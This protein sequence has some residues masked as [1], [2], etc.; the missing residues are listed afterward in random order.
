MDEVFSCGNEIIKDILL[1]QLH[2]SFVPLL[3]ILGPAANAGR[4]V[5]D[6]LFEQSNPKR[7]KCRRYGNVEAA[8]TIQK[9]RIVAVEIQ[10]LLVDNKHRHSSA[11]FTCVEDLFRFVILSAEAL[12][13]WGPEQAR[14]ARRDVVFVDRRRN[15]QGV[16]RIENEL[17]VSLSAKTAGGARSGQLDF[18]FH[19]PGKIV[20]VGASRDIL[21]ILSED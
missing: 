3:A 20:N 5:D 2:A 21:Q 10:A 17:V 18:V 4:H 9:R 16:E 13:L 8:I 11:I 12:N 19:F 15:V 7:A 6:P 14:T 1:V